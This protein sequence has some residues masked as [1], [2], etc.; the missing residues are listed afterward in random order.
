MEISL[1]K[2]RFTIFSFSLKRFLLIASKILIE[3]YYKRSYNIFYI[4]IHWEATNGIMVRRWKFCENFK[5]IFI[6]RV[7]E[8]FHIMSI[9]AIYFIPVSAFIRIF[10]ISLYTGR[11]RMELWLGVENFAKI[12]SAKVCINKYSVLVGPRPQYLI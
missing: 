6:N 3:Y 9:Q 2:M 11:Q 10:F 5:K 4:V 7:N 8:K 12:Q 1:P